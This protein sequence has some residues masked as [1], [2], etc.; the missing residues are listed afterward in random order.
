MDNTKKITIELFFMKLEHN[1]VKYLRD[2]INITHQ[3]NDPDTYVEQALLTD[4]HPLSSLVKKQYIIHSTSWRYETP[5]TLILTYVIYSDHIDFGSNSVKTLPFYSLHI[6]KGE[7]PHR[8]RPKVILEEHVIAHALRHLGFLVQSDHKHLYAA[9]LSP[10]TVL[11][12]QTLHASL[13]GKLES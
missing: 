7:H 13:G 9:M 4:L 6:A 12:L 5:N 10:E 8:P 1:V 11:K 3:P 2:E